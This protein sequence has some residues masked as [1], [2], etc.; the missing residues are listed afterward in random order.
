MA[1]V[2]LAI[3]IQGARLDAHR[4]E[5]IVNAL[6]QVR[7]SIVNPCVMQPPEKHESHRYNA[8][9]VFR[10]NLERLTSAQVLIAE[11]SAP[12][13]G[14]GYEIATAQHLGLPILCLY[15][16]VDEAQVSLMIRGIVY[17][18]LRVCAY[19]DPSSLVSVIE[20]ALDE[21]AIGTEASSDDTSRYADAVTDHFTRL[22]V[23]YDTS[24][25]WREHPDIL[26]WF[27][28]AV[29]QG[30]VCLDVGTGTGLVGGYLRARGRRVVGIDLVSQMLGR[31]GNRLD[32]VVRARAEALPLADSCFDVVTVRQLLHYVDDTACLQE[33]ARVIVPRGYL[34]CAQVAA[35]DAEL[36]C[37]WRE[38][39]A[40]VQPLRRRYYTEAALIRL[41]AEAGFR[42]SDGEYLQV[43]RWDSWDR[44]LINCRGG[45]NG[46]HAVHA[47]LANTPARVADRLGLHLSKEG[48]GYIQQ[49]LLLEARRK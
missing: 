3:P 2:F 27:S 11:I 14:V 6:D 46:A 32:G 24:T 29:P 13:L 42:V 39:K 1:K 41:V 5:A 31:A 20:T 15:R 33:A 47:F 37:W 44:F 8:P 21:F 18:R 16:K 38:L 17:N 49:W 4:Y 10:D 43:S 26:E 45:A 22:A 25:E 28:R 36:A 23:A 35:P 48:V 40:R 30:A 34:A 12:S 9:S 19:N 7:C